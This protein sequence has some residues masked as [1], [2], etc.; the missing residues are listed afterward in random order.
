MANSLSPLPI[1]FIHTSENPAAVPEYLLSA[2]MQARLS[3]P[4]QKIVLLS[5]LKNFRVT[6]VPEIDAGFAYVDIDPFRGACAEF[7]K[8]YFNLSVNPAWYERFCFERWFILKAFC[9]AHNVNRLI[10]FDSDVLIYSDLEEVAKAY[11]DCSYVNLTYGCWG[12]VL[13]NDLRALDRYL[14]IVI[15]I[16][17][18]NSPLWIKA[19]DRLGLTKPYLG[20]ATSGVDNLTDMFAIRMLNDMSDDLPYQD[21]YSIKN[22][23]CFDRNIAVT[24]AETKFD[25]HFESSGPIKYVNWV[26]GEPFGRAKGFSEPIKFHCLHFQGHAKSFIAEWF[27]KNLE[28]WLKKNGYATNLPPAS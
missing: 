23:G 5:N 28:L 24:A 26:N 9:D 7:T 21:L 6:A 16:F 8:R 14:S 13:F 20:G 3:N 18:R 4:K 10:A 22:L 17:S 1:V 27:L 12:T 2:M 11:S 19:M 25:P 15:E